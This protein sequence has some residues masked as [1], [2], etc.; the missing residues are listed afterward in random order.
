MRK[1]F[2][3]RVRDVNSC[4][5]SRI[6]SALSAMG[7]WVFF[8]SFAG[9]GVRNV[10]GWIPFGV[11]ALASTAFFVFLFFRSG[12]EITWRRV[13]TT[14]LLFVAWCCISVVWSTYRL[15]TIVASLLMLVT[16][17]GGILLA[18][19]FPLRQLLGILTRSLQWMLLLSL[20]LE[21]FVAFVWREPF[22]PLY[23]RNWEHIPPSYYWVHGLIFEGGPVQGVF[24]NRN[25]MGFGALLGLICFLMQYWMEIRSLRSTL[26]WTALSIFFLL[27]T[28]SATVSLCLLSCAVVF[29]AIAYLRRVPRVDR[30]AVSYRLMMLAVFGGVAACALADSIFTFMG[31]STDLTGRGVIWERL[32]V[33]WAQKP[34]LG[35]GWI[36]YWPPWIPMFRTLVVR[37]DGTPTMQAHNALI[38][39][40]FQTG[41]IG[42]LLLFVA[43]AW[44]GFWMLK[45][46][47]RS[48]ALDCSAVWG[49]VLLT[50]LLVQSLTESRLLS[51]GNWVLFVALATWLTV[52]GY[53]TRI[54]ESLLSR[55]EVEKMPTV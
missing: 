20:V 23:M 7:V 45:A 48:S 8:I 30:A 53:R 14:I 38:E 35:W 9:Q 40:L 31:R 17:L 37:P 36:M 25:P 29:V 10:I 12:R 32:L 50:A 46:G 27:E 44:V 21:L 34:V 24:A 16:T 2:Q 49:A 47:I 26:L 15:E 52:H 3:Q 41:A 4:P 18:I 54:A 42:A 55:R 51:E 6:E 43:M 33:L 11:L 5:D 19:A 39:A 28:R 22:A 13:P 1:L